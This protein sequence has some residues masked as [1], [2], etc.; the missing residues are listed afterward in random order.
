MN[1]VHSFDS[2]QECCIGFGYTFDSISHL[3]AY[4]LKETWKPQKF[5][6]V[7]FPRKRI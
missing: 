1:S 6:Q 3:V 2:N 4:I 5:T 7:V